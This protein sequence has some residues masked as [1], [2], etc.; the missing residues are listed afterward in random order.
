MGGFMNIRVTFTSHKR[1]WSSVAM[2]VGLVLT[3]N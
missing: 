3:I 1:T 2:I